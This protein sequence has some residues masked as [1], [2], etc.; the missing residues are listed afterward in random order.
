VGNLRLASQGRLWELTLQ[1]PDALARLTLRDESLDRVLL[2][3]EQMLGVEEAPWETDRWL[4]E[5]AASKPKKKKV[6]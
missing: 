6:D 2:L 4:A 3:A 5:R 1:D